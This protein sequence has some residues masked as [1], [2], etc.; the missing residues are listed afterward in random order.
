M[1]LRSGSCCRGAGDRVAAGDNGGRLWR[2]R[3]RT[4]READ[5][6]AAERATAESLS[7]SASASPGAAHPESVG[8]APP[9]PVALGEARTPAAPKPAARA[10][11]PAAVP[12]KPK[13]TSLPPPVPAPAAAAPD[14][15][16]SY[17]GTKAG[18][19]QVKQALEAAA[20][21]TYWPTSAPEI[22]I[23]ANLVKATA[24]QES[25]WQSQHHR[26][27]RRRRADAG[28][29][30]HGP[31]DESA[32]RRVVRHRR[33]SGQRLP[34][35]DVPGVADEVHR[36]H[37]LRRQLQPR[38]GELLGRA[39]TPASSTRSSRPTTT[40]TPRSPPTTAW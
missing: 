27:R 26:L 15:T 31:V 2:R 32:V 22:S 20:A 17:S 8:V 36:G 19:E 9:E 4:R 1:G 30:R 35:C 5:F 25:G 34:G 21:R 7:A 12:A 11:K 33:P 29:A 14:C 18:T 38:P 40:A 6:R 23:P 28:H 13:E 16:P 3:R 10:P 37:V 24:W 39:R